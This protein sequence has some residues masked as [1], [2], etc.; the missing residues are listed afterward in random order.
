GKQT[1]DIYN[2]MGTRI[3]SMT[4]GQAESNLL[5]EVSLLDIPNGIYLVRL[6]NDKAEVTGKIIVIH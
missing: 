4:I 5:T 1:L 3:Y 6:G 2:M